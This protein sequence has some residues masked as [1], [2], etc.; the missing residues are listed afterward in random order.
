MISSLD[1]R[2]LHQRGSAEARA[3][4]LPEGLGPPSAGEKDSHAQAD[5]RKRSRTMS[6]TKS[7]F[8]VILRAKLKKHFP[9]CPVAEEADVPRSGGWWIHIENG[10]AIPRFRLK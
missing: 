8:V 1:A 3:G 10:D 9:K 5:T 4:V 6:D 2:L 7:G